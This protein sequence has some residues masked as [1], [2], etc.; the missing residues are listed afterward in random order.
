[1]ASNFDS[2]FLLDCDLK[3]K[4]RQLSPL[5]PS[6]SLSSSAVL[7]YWGD[8]REQLSASWNRLKTIP[9]NLGCQMTS[10]TKGEVGS[11]NN[12]LSSKGETI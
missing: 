7:A 11:L 2:A 5:F 8:G 6:L 3:S 4:G 12:R 10:W 9:D 1:M